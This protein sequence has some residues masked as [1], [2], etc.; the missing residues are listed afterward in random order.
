MAKR[1]IPKLPAILN[2][3]LATAMTHSTRAHAMGILSDRVASPQGIGKEIGETTQNVSYHLGIL[4]DLDC[5]ELVESKPARGGG[6]VEHFYRATKRP[7]F[8]KKGWDQLD[9]NEKWG[10]AIPILRV[11]SKELNES[12]AAGTFMDPDDAH[13]SR[14]PMVLDPEGYE[15]SK[16]ILGNALKEL[17]KEQAA[18]AKRCKDGAQETML[19]KVNI[20]QFRSPGEQKAA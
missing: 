2:P 13:L 19:F 6:V 1:S 16:A 7:Y 5:I 12:L 9:D 20:I 4:E 17:L 14:T 18:V 8:D 10:T 15:N 11:I 3:T